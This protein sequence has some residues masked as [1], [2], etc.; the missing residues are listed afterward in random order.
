MSAPASSAFVTRATSPARAAFHNSS[1]IAA[2]AAGAGCCGAE[3]VWGASVT[4]SASAAAIVNIVG[5]SESGRIPDRPMALWSFRRLVL[6]AA[7]LL[8]ILAA[9]GLLVLRATLDPEALRRAAETRLSAMLGQPVSIAGV[10][11]SLF[12]VP[13]LIGD[14][15][16]LGAERQAP[17]LALQ[18]IRI[19]PSLGSLLRGPYVIREVTLEGLTVRVVRE[20]P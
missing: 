6:F 12:P 9:A 16:V 3:G 20:S 19:V 13:A 17:D 15:I 14:G 18:R 8:A 11:V 2:G 10:H 4:D 7:L 1:V 5:S